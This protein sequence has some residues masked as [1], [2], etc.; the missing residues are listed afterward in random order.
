MLLLN[1]IVAASQSHLAAIG[2]V[3]VGEC[4][5]F[6]WHIDED[7]IGPSGVIREKSREEG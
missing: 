7:S 1:M 3:K 2:L 4:C 5:L 6:S